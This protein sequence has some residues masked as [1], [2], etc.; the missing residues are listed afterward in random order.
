VQASAATAA[1][2]V[3][4]VMHSSLSGRSQACFRA[5]RQPLRHSRR[6]SRQRDDTGPEL[7]E[8]AGVDVVFSRERQLAIIADAINDEGGRQCRAVAHRHRQDAG[9]DQQFSGRIDGEGAKVNGVRLDVL[10][11]RGLA[12][13]LVDGERCDIVLAPLNTFLPPTSSVLELRL[14]MV[15]NRPFG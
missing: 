5:A 9:C 1:M 15:T 3:I 6:A 10:N 14:V 2:S 13:G 4:L 11:Q 7:H 12:G 8:A